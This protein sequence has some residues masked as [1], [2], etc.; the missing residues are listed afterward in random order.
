MFKHLNWSQAGNTYFTMGR[1][2]AVGRLQPAVGRRYSKL[3]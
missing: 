1:Q 2:V 3:K